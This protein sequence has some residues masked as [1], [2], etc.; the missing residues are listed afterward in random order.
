MKIVHLIMFHQ[1]FT[2]TIVDFFNRNFSDQ[3]FLVHHYQNPLTRGI[4]LPPNAFFVDLSQISTFWAQLETASVIV[5]HGYLFEDVIKL[6]SRL[7][8][9]LEKTAV[10]IWGAD[11]YNNAIELSV[12]PSFKRRFH[13]ILNEA[14]KKK[15]MRPCRHLMAFCHDD[16]LLAQ[17]KY[18]CHADYFECLYPQSLNA[19]Q[20]NSSDE[21]KT[22]E[23]RV[24][25]GNSAAETNN[26][27]ACLESL[28]HLSGRNL[29]VY[30]PLSYGGT[31]DYIQKVIAMG[32]RYFGNSFVPLLDYMTIEKYVS[33][34]SSMNAVI[35]N[36]ER[37]QGTQNI[38]IAGFYGC[39]IFMN[40]TCPLWDKYVKND[41]CF[42][43]DTRLIKNMSYESFVETK[44]EN[45][46]Y[47]KHYFDQVWNEDYLK[48]LWSKVF[49]SI[50]KN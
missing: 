15:A 12:S 38:E 42:F 9:L 8:P 33:L 27:H 17:K 46:I 5:I 2:L 20:M 43:A 1:R 45:R 22:S 13:L 14:Q 28:S 40:P 36:Y 30:C 10:V 47:N 44:D 6:I 11:L 35:F 49:V 4:V 25:V 29:K 23:F 7:G 48:R 21:G 37:Q 24:M 50:N 39:K 26:H 31:A 3:V 32:H 16:Y 34:F 18:H 41:G 19:S